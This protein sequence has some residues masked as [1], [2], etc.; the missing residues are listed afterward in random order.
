ML[1]KTQSRCI[2]M[3]TADVFN[4]YTAHASFSSRHRPVLDTGCWTN[5]RRDGDAATTEY[6]ACVV[7]RNHQNL[8]ASCYRSTVARSLNTFRLSDEISA[9]LTTWRDIAAKSEKISCYVSRFCYDVASSTA[10]N[11][12]GKNEKNEVEHEAIT[13]GISLESARVDHNLT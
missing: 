3:S 1:Q 6:A 4:R 11:Q 5:P 10:R 7:R 13:D 8:I 9:P 2:V 12:I